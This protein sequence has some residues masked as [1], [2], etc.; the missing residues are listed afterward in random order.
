MKKVIYLISL[1]LL[2]SASVKSQDINSLFTEIIAAYE[3]RDLEVMISKSDELIALESDHYAGYLFKAMALIAKNDLKEAAAYTSTASMINPVDFASYAVQSYIFYL[4]GDKAKAERYMHFS[5]Q[6][7]NSPEAYKDVLLDIDFF[8]HF[9]DTDF[10]ELREMVNRITALYPNSPWYFQQMNLCFQAW[11]NNSTCNDIQ[12]VTQYFNGLTPKNPDIT[13]FIA[14]NKANTNYA[15]NDFNGAV[16]EA[17]IFL[18]QAN[19]NELPMSYLQGTAYIIKTTN[20]DA[21]FE[22]DKALLSAQRGLMALQPMQTPLILRCTLLNWVAAMSNKTGDATSAQLAYNKLLNEAERLQS[23]YWMAVA[24]NAV[25]GPLIMGK[26]KTMGALYLEQAWKLAQNTGDESLMDEIKAN[27]AIVLWQKGQH[28]QATILLEQT[29][30]QQIENENYLEAQTLSNNLGFMQFTSESYVSAAATFRRAINISEK[31]RSKLTAD[32][33]LLMMTEHSSSYSGLIMSYTKLN[34]AAAMF[35]VQDMNRS[36]LLL[37][38]FDSNLPHVSLSQAQAKLKEDEVLLYYS[39]FG[40]GEMAVTA[41]TKNSA[42]IRY[43]FPIKSWLIMQKAFTNRI[44]KVPSQ[45]NGQTI[46]W[47]EEIINGQIAKI[48]FK[49]AAFTAKDFNTFTEFTISLLQSYDDARANLRNQFLQQWHRFLIE[50]VADI[51]EG[52]KTIIISGEGVLNYLPFETFMNVNGKYLIESHNVKYIPSAT[53]W[54]NIQDRNYGD[55]RKPLLAMGGATYKSPDKA[56]AESRGATSILELKNDISNKVKQNDNLLP[57]LTAL[58]FNG[59]NYLPGTLEEVN[60]LKS[61]V[62]EATLLTGNQ[63][64]ESDIKHLNSTGELKQYQW[65]HIATH[66]FA[67]D[68]IPD[69]SGVMMTQPPNGDENEDTY[70]LAHEIAR[71]DLNADLVVLSACET[72]LGKVYAGEGVNGLNSAL[73]VAGANNSLLSLWPVSDAGTMLLM[74]QLYENLY[75][76]KQS[77]EE[78]INNAKRYMQSGKAGPQFSKPVIWAP[79]VINGK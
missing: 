16:K 27:Y 62:P 20:D 79:F 18:D 35:K 45:I 30:K 3:G 44:N 14:L 49:E 23:D 1:L 19:Q 22:F 9:L 8:A 65:V 36:R 12:E 38:K 39:L 68:F 5:L 77:V 28:V 54:A 15:F 55:G 76:K 53:I 57:E 25:G 66:G 29:Y 31:Y 59:A 6:L 46:Q 2:L 48:S 11:Q 60:N 37:E 67:L 34:D 24:F 50:P 69:L 41:I 42:E 72:A 56:P 4:K 63:M 74:T 70:L 61:I 21:H 75:T 13:P 51:I 26:D 64:K 33:Q 52:K 32:Q 10:T 43:N 73:L 40:G 7:Q 78:A 58:G 71:L 47:D 17:N